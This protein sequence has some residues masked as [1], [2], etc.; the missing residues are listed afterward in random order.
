M[1][2]GVL[3]SKKYLIHNLL[4]YGTATDNEDSQVAT[5]SMIFHRLQPMT[6]VYTATKIMMGS[7]LNIW[8]G[9]DGS[10]HNLWLGYHFFM[11]AISLIMG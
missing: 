8:A 6:N 2:V 5:I 4:S 1:T 11:G 7:S 10:Y 9:Y 3:H